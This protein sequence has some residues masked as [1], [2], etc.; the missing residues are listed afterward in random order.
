MQ[1]FLGRL[2]KLL[3]NHCATPPG[4]DKFAQSFPQKK[5]V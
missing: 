1:Q 4:T 5:L 2:V 3:K